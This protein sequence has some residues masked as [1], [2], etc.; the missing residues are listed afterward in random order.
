MKRRMDARSIFFLG[1]SVPLGCGLLLIHWAGDLYQGL[2]EPEEQLAKGDVI[3]ILAGGRGRIQAGARLF[4][5]YKEQHQERLPVYVA[6][7]GARPEQ[8][9]AMIPGEVRH[10]MRE[11]DLITERES[12]NTEGNAKFFLDYASSKGFRKV[13]LVTS[14][15]HIKRAEWIFHLM[16][17][18]RDLPLQLLTYPV[19]VEPFLA[20]KWRSSWTGVRVSVREYLKWLYVATFWSPGSLAAEEDLVSDE[21]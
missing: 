13:W 1:L 10:E 6:G 3:V 7:I 18:K 2:R 15:Y 19:L 5:R 12:T 16:A 14:G 4:V 11:S 8:V 17:E 20:S 9:F 21:S